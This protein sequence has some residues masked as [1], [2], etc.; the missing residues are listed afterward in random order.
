MHQGAIYPHTQLVVSGIGVVRRFNAIPG[1]GGQ[2]WATI[3][4][5]HFRCDVIARDMVSPQNPFDL[6]YANF[7]VGIGCALD[8]H[9]MFVV[10]ARIITQH[11]AEIYV[12][13]HM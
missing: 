7:I 12:G 9:N 5:R 2:L 4:L 13:A 1:I 10:I 8:A 11:L 6:T 3:P